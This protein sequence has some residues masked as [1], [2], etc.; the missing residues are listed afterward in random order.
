M[1]E[2]QAKYIIPNELGLHARV[3]S[4]LVKACS[5]FSSTIRFQS[6]THDVNAKSVLDLLTLGAEQGAALTVNISGDDAEDALQAIDKL[7]VN[8]LGD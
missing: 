4:R 3:A 8:N 7:F 2:L 1:V 5:A 6:D